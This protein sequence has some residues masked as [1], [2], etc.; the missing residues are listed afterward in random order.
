MLHIIAS[1]F[2]PSPIA[3]IITFILFVLIVPIMF[4]MFFWKSERGFS[5]GILITLILA[6]SFVSGV[7]YLA[8][9]NPFALG[10]FGQ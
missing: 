8:L 10:D 5:I 3:I 1:L 9:T 2:N 4:S 6:I 7:F